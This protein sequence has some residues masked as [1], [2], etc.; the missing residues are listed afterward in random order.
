[1][2]HAIA[3]V[4]GDL[5]SFD[6]FEQLHS[7][8]ASVQMEGGGRRSPAGGSP[9]PEDREMGDGFEGIVTTASLQQPSAVAVLRG[10]SS[11]VTAVAWSPDMC[12]LVTGSMS[13]TACIWQASGPNPWQW[14]A[15]K[16]LRGFADGFKDGFR[17][18]AW[19][20]DGSRLAAAGPDSAARVW[21]STGARDRQWDAVCAL[22]GHTG[23]LWDIAW[24]PSGKSL[25]TGSDDKTA[26]IWQA[27]RADGS[28]W[29]VVALLRGHDEG[30]RAV[31]WAPDGKQVLTGSTDATAAV[32]R[33]YLQAA[34]W[35]LAQRLVRHS[36]P[37]QAVAWAPQGDVLLTAGDDGCY[38][39]C[40]ACCGG[41]ASWE[42]VAAVP[43]E[44]GILAAAWSPDGT[45]LATAGADA[46]LRL[47]NLVAGGVGC[48]A[49][50]DDAEPA[51]AEL[52]YSLELLAALE[53]H[54]DA[55]ST[56]CWSADGAR[57]ATGSADQTARVWEI[58]P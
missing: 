9:L 33:P 19:S 52:Q 2:L 32:W 53:G 25:L 29:E 49:G 35:C 30:I 31:A 21:R 37:V 23:A 44:A 27:S 58:P 4:A 16:T 24:S 13:N 22:A 39:W 7:E 48:Q 36:G 12:R 41:E 26:R 50:A 47:W 57:L 3:V 40:E 45:R 20:P 18:I 6:P 17:A 34:G 51:E 56:V 11:G 15:V 55:I 38:L 42:A 10:H 46:V 14:R 54:R 5:P 43:D 8:F 1:M 28:H